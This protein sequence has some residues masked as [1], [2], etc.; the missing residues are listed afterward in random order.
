[1]Q[2]TFELDDHEDGVTPIDTASALIKCGR[3]NE[4]QL[5]QIAD[6]LLIAIGVGATTKEKWS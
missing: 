1:M 5:E 2:I 4:H 3:F 6:H